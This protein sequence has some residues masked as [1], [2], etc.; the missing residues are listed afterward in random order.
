MALS[1]KSWFSEPILTHDEQYVPAM[2]Q[3]IVEP[4]KIDEPVV[5]FPIA[6]GF[7]VMRAPW[8]SKHTPETKEFKDLNLVYEF[9]KG[10]FRWPRDSVTA[11]PAGK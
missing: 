5:V 4:L 9:L 3:V 10:H 2:K 6:N 1:W 7:A 8:I 11:S